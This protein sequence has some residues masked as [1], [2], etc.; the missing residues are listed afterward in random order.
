MVEGE[1][2]CHEYPPLMVGER[3][4]LYAMPM[5]TRDV[6]GKRDNFHEYQSNGGNREGLP[7]VQE[8]KVE[9]DGL[10]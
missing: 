10:P 1:K 5:S 2:I 7:G 6:C 9:R 4:K 3:D 8:I